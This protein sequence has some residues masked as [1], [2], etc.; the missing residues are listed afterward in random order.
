[1]L[2]A[3]YPNLEL[4]EYKVTRALKADEVFIKSFQ[5]VREQNRYVSIQLEAIMFPQTWPTTSLGFDRMPDGSPAIGGQ[6]FTTAYTTVF[7]ELNTDSYVVCFG[8]K[9][10]YK[11]ENA[12]DAFFND[13][14]DRKM[15]SLSDAFKRY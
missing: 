15:A 12:N 2:R 5:K 10:C 4:L 9:H 3:Q 6:A 11:V 8:A 14:R 1:M 13:L 7:H